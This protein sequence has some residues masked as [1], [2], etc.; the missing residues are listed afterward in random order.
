MSELSPIYHVRQEELEQFGAEAR[1]QWRLVLRRFLRHRLAITSLLFLMGLIVLSL[2][3]ERIVGYTFSDLSGAYSQAPSK[4]HWFGTDTIGHDSFARTMRGARISL[5]VAVLVM[6][7]S[8]TIGT[9]VGAIAGYFRGWLDGL[10]M[11][12]TDLFLSI[13]LLAI[14]L[15]VA[16]KYRGQRNN[17][18]AIVLLISAFFWMGLARIVRGVFLSLREREFVEAARALGAGN[19]RIIFRHILPNAVGPI[20]V[21]ATLA[22]AVAILLEAAL[23][24]LGFGVSP[25]DIS[26]GKLVSEGVQAMRTRWWLFYLP[27]LY[28]IAMVLCINFIGDGLRDAFDPQQTRVRE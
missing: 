28:L 1:A 12:V 11:R 26:L 7:I 5:Q 8:T 19:F 25:P 15:V 4:E 2:V 18:T 20:I 21:N 13:P 14:L 9:T 24:F 27:G 3:G 23:S 10:L 16:S 6:L 22:I 17:I